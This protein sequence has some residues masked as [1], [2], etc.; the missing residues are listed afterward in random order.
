MVAY[1]PYKQ[2]NVAIPDE[3]SYNVLDETTGKSYYCFLYSR[4]KLDIDEIMVSVE[5][6]TGNMWDRI[7][8]ALGKNLVDN[9]NIEFS[10]TENI[11][12]KGKS[13]GKSVIPVLVEVNHINK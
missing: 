13:G 8:A 9:S 10:T 7:K 4:N 11:S 6:G 5:N 3:E 2:N 1:L 12:F